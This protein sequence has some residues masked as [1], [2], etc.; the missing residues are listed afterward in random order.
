MVINVLLVLCE[1]NLLPSVFSVIAITTMVG[2]KIFNKTHYISININ[3]FDG[4]KLEALFNIRDSDS[5]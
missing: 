5:Q 1:A 2:I 4:S 3:E